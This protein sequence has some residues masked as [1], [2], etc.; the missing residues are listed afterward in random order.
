MTPMLSRRA[1][2]L[3]LAS[4]LAGR[5]GLAHAE[6]AIWVGHDIPPYLS[7]GAKGPD[8]YAF[9]LFQRVIR[10]AQLDAVLQI[11]PWAR[12]WRMLQNGQAEAAF[13]VTRSPD[14]ETQ[15]RWLFPVG[16]FRFAAYT[17][18][19]QGPLAGELSALKALRVG[20]LRASL[21]RSLLQPAGVTQVVEGKDFTELLALLDRG[22]VDAVIGPEPVLRTITPEAGAKRLRITTMNQGYELYAVASAAMSDDSVRRVMAAYQHLVDTGVVAQLRKTYPEAMPVY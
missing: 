1:A 6:S 13:P 2:Y 8:G 21:G 22:I 18:Y 20:A 5:A 15:Y 10:Q 7:I 12:T 17:R 14:R 9:H 16:R 4:L 19:A 3:T 11:Y